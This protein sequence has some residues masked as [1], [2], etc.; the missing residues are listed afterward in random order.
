MD[1]TE[2][3]SLND[4]LPCAPTVYK[5]RLR[6]TDTNQVLRGSSAVG[7]ARRLESQGITLAAAGII[8]SDQT[9]VQALATSTLSSVPS[10][11]SKEVAS[12]SE[13]MRSLNC[14]TFATSPAG[15]VSFS[16]IWSETSRPAGLTGV[17]HGADYV[18]GRSS[19]TDRRSAR[20]RG[21][22]SRRSAGPRTR[23]WRP[24]RRSVPPRC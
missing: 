5:T 17:L 9:S 8:A 14:S 7:N 6:G 2:N 22:R 15:T 11:T 21:S 12:V 24:L 4:L 10:F 3:H 18:R 19:A 1:G 13:V 23:N 16:A 20:C